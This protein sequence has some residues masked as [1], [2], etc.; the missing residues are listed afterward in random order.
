M[1][2][3]RFSFQSC[4][5]NKKNA[6]LNLLICMITVLLMNVFAQNLIHI[7]E[8]LDDL[9]KAVEIDAIV[10]NLCGNMS[11][12]LNIPER[13]VDGVL[14]SPH[15]KN[16]VITAR[17][18]LGFGEFT[19]D[20]YE[21]YL[22]Y[23]ATGSNS[24]AGIPGLK[25]DE[26]TFVDGQDINSFFSSE[27]RVCVID[28]RLLKEEQL[29]VGEEVTIT[30]YRYR[31]GDYHFIY[32]EPLESSTYRI[33][34]S[35]DMKEYIGESVKPRILFPLKT[36][37]KLFDEQNIPFGADTCSFQVKDPFLLNEFKQEMH[38]LGFLPVYA[39]AEFQ[40]D[41]NALT[42]KDET[43]VHSAE[44]LM[45]NQ[46]LMYSI[47]PFLCF[48]VLC[49]GFV[50]AELLMKQRTAEYAMMR[51]LGQ[52]HRESLYM[53]CLEYAMTAFGGG[54]FGILIGVTLLHSVPGIA[55]IATLVFLLCYIIGTIAALSSLKG[56]SIIS[57]LSKND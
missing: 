8:Q 52:N 39:T 57:V 30:T 5:R 41:G 15:V 55:V 54:I 14:S 9:P 22:N 4:L 11:A 12:V 51:S 38:D 37:R 2:F 25:E 56:M 28:S 35:M 17:L 50:M 44:Q 6:A 45:K 24:I 42:V 1:R 32:I 43:F 36:V 19:I 26:L 48:A 34:G 18:K 23:Y 7:Q 46:K 10:S 47:L 13:Y 49:I 33:V 27:E 21:D 40:Y 16:P 53:L 31:Y 3:L 29:S 20:E